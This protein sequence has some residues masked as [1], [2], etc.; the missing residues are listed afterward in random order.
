[1]TKTATINLKPDHHSYTI[2]SGRSYPLGAT[3]DQYGTNF[4]LFSANATKVELCL[5]DDSGIDEI[6]RIELPEFTDDIWHGYV[7][8][9]VAGS[10]YGYRVHGPFEPHNGHRFNPYKLLLDPYAKK[11]S[12]EFISSDNHFSYNTSTNNSSDNKSLTI[13]PNSI[14][15]QN[16]AAYLP[17]CVV[18]PALPL[19]NSHPQIRRRDTIIYEM[20]VKGFTQ[21]HPNV[22]IEL[23][24]T[25]AG[26]A[27]KAVCD[28]L[29][30]LGVTTIELLPVHQFIN[31]AFVEQKN[32]TNYWGYNSIGFFLP[33]DQYNHSGELEE[34]KQ[35]VES[36]HQAGIEVILD[37]VYNHTAEGNELGPTYSF[38]GIDNAS[39]YRLQSNDKRYYTNYSGC[40]NTLNIQHPRVMQLVL[41]SLRYWVDVMGID[42]FRFDLAPI[43]GRENSEFNANNIFFSA[44]RQDPIL[45]KVKLIAEPWDIGENGYQLGKFPNSWLEWNDRFRDTCRKFW[46]GDKG[47]A[48][49]F[50]R[51]LHGSSDLFEKPSRRPSASVNMIT[52]HDGFNLH[53]LVTYKNK[54]NHA[55]GEHNK[56][57]HNANFSANFGVEGPCDDPEINTL[58]ARQKRNLLTTLFI[59]QGTPMLLAGDEI[60]HSQQG[61]NN[62]YCQ[63]NEL[64][65]INWNKPQA[66]AELAFVKQL[67]ALRKAH[68]LLNRTHYQHGLEVSEKTGLP[69]ISWLNCTGKLMAENNWHDTNIKCFAMLLAQT[70]PDKKINN[71]SKNNV[72]QDDA[73][74]IIFNAHAYEIN[75][76]LPKLHG[77]WQRLIDTANDNTDKIPPNDTDL[78]K[79]IN[80]I[81]PLIVIKAHSCIVLSFIQN[82]SQTFTTNNASSKSTIDLQQA[83]AFQQTT[84]PQIKSIE[85]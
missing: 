44:I 62:A 34:F 68:P 80:I 74:L 16:N 19:C 29:I 28:Y 39:Y 61:N 36:F 54:H 79:D 12:G 22:P 17:K 35:M 58:R 43:L 1:M 77:Y 56:D 57:G 73:L 42:G 49:E 75:Y 30:D 67:I 65:W 7:E 5:F 66:K 40:G 9:V 82:S 3:C 37:V 4:A 6:A 50:A 25:Y 52:S 33:H 47:I 85:N 26:L 14:N 11:I 41:D 13:D 21:L 45:A 76:Q 18:T 70:R 53:D 69:D 83:N 64:A 20:H 84:S 2:G 10:K 60:A 15:Q 46:R 38:K 27:S 55:N 71:E 72:P 23:K 32:L 63:D 24:G 78:K 81:E 59:A 8:G 51:R 48:P 31:E